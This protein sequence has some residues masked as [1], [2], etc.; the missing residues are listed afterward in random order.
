MRRTASGSRAAQARDPEEPFPVGLRGGN[1]GADP[2]EG[3]AVTTGPDTLCQAFSA[4][5]VLTRP[6]Q[7]GRSRRKSRGEKLSTTARLLSGKQSS[8]VPVVLLV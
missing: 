3:G 7:K 1:R 5:T 2:A 8:V 4:S 6:A